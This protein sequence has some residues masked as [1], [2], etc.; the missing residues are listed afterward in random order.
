M[1]IGVSYI[2]GGGSRTFDL[3]GAPADGSVAANI[4]GASPLHAPKFNPMA[5]ALTPPEAAAQIPAMADDADKGKVKV[6]E[7]D[8]PEVLERK[9]EPSGSI[10]AQG[11]R[12]KLKGDDACAGGRMIYGSNN[13]S[14]GFFSL[15]QLDPLGGSTILN[16]TDNIPD[17]NSAS[18]DGLLGATVRIGGRVVMEFIASESESE[19]GGEEGDESTPKSHTFVN[20][21]EFYRLAEI[22]PNGRIERVS[23]E[24]E[25]PVLMFEI[26]GGGS[27][28]GKYGVRPFWTSAHDSAEKPHLDR[29]AFGAEADLDTW[30]E[31]KE[32]FGCN[33]DTDGNLVED[34]PVKIV[35]TDRCRYATGE[36]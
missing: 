5:A 13:G 12:L 11:G 20:V 34:P 31:E 33:Y 15:R 22:T 29:L 1:G 36:E 21:K 30:D 27:G 19:D 8:V 7:G 10:T 2:G 28:N 4:L 35:E 23:Q 26:G 24:I 14:R 16:S 6:S 9:I 17:G 3:D 32:R 25:Q 18:M